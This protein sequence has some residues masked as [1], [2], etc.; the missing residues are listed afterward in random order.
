MAIR[1]FRVGAAGS[2]NNMCYLILGW[3][4]KKIEIEIKYS[5]KYTPLSNHVWTCIGHQRHHHRNAWNNVH[6]TL[7]WFDCDKWIELLLLPVLFFPQFYFRWS[8]FP[9]SFDRTNKSHHRYIRMKNCKISSK[10][11]SHAIN[12]QLI[13]GFSWKIERKL[14]WSEINLE[15]HR[16]RCACAS[17]CVCY[18]REKMLLK[19]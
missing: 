18:L 6:R 12:W 7:Y 5:I 16:C 19:T 8:F 11:E 4:G 9:R 3:W 14:H 1:P 15:E 2:N 13:I 17:H 10:N